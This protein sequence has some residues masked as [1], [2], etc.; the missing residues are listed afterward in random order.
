LESAAARGIVG[1]MDGT[2]QTAGVEVWER[3]GILFEIYAYD[4]GPQAALPVHTHEHYQWCLSVDF[5]GCYQYRGTRHAVPARAVSVIHPYEP[6]AAIDPH[7]R[8]RRCSFVLANIPVPVM[9]DVVT[10]LGGHRGLTP[11]F[12]E[13][14]SLDAGVRSGF[15]ALQRTSVADSDRLAF[16]TALLSLIRRTLPAM[17]STTID[18]ARGGRERRAV[19]A[20]RD[21]LHDHTAG[22]VPLAVLGDVAGL[23]QRQL[24]RAFRQA[25]GLSPHRYQLQLRVDRAKARIADGEPLAQVA[26]ATGFVDQS[27]LSRQFHRYVG[28]PPGHYRP[29]PYPSGPPQGSVETHP[30]LEG[31]P[32]T[33]IRVSGRRHQ[34]GSHAPG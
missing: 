31:R 1:G 22:A 28:F 34:V 15:L 8:D 24:F 11:F 20:A 32:M 33:T 21:Y 18:P 12:G 10:E 7:S 19:L 13:V 29:R 6:H 4:P 16:D 2:A 3:A 25:T 17:A 14:V 30:S 27:H 5:P 23:S 26:A 9:Q